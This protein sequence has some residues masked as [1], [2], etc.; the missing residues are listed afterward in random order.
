MSSDYQATL[1]QAH[2]IGASKAN[3]K[4]L[5]AM[6]CESTLQILCGAVS[7]ELV[8]NG[9]QAKNMTSRE[10]MHL[11]GTDPDAVADLMWV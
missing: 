9:A 5:T 6:F 7:P 10:L 4:Q 3:D 8:F 11:A 1:D 2:E